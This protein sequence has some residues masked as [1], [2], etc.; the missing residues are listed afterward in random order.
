MDIYAVCTGKSLPA[1]ENEYAGKG[2]GEFKAAVAEAVVEELRPIQERYK[3]Y[4]K[5]KTYLTDCM[6]NNAEKAA[7]RSRRT[8]DKAMKKIGFLQI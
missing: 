5:E 4:V 2:Y 1:I 6:K 7:R 8:L 3:Q